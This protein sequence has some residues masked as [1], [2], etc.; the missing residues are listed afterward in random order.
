MLY[1]AGVRRGSCCC[2]TSLLAPSHRLEVLDHRC[3]V[4]VDCAFERRDSVVVRFVDIGLG[5]DERLHDLQV[6]KV[7]SGG[8]GCLPWGKGVMRNEYDQDTRVLTHHLPLTHEER[9]KK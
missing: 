4:V 2:A 3:V 6:A 5:T 7:R 1:C 9:N 8:E